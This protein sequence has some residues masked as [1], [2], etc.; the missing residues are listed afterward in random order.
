MVAD[1]SAVGDPL[2]GFDIYDSYK[3]GKECEFPRVEGGW[4]TFGGTSLSTPLIAGLYGLAGGGHGLTYPGL[5]LYGREADASSRFDVTSGGNGICGG[6]VPA[7]CGEP[8]REI[9][10]LV[11][12]EGTTACDAAPGFDGPS[13]VGTPEGFGLFKPEAPTAV[14]SAPASVFAA[15]PAEFDGRSSVD[16]YPGVQLTRYVWSWG[17]GNES[18]GPN[19]THVYASPGKYTVGLTVTDELGLTSAQVTTSVTAATATPPTAVTGKASSITENGATLNATV[20]PNG[21]A[22]TACTFEY[23]T[24]ATPYEKTAPCAT[25]PGSGTT[26]V[27]VSAAVSGLSASTTYH[28]RIVAD[29]ASTTK[30][31]GSDEAFKTVATAPTAVTGKASSITEKGATLNATVNPN[32]TS[33]T[34]CTFEYGTSTTP[35]EK[36]APCATLPGSGTTAVA[37]SAAVSGLSASTTYHFRIVAENTSPTKGEGADEA[38]KTVGPPTAVTGKASSITENGA[39]LNA[40]VNPNGIAVTACTFEYGS[41]AF[42]AIAQTYELTAGCATLPRFGH[43][44]VAVSAAVS[45]LAPNDLPLPRRGR[46]RFHDDQGGRRR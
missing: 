17:D 24:S 10:A 15:A 40:T 18:E 45:G 36:T 21:I 26:P 4:A 3:C 35:Y 43:D 39:T 2:T 44:P 37:V 5:T 32:G 13:G 23:G 27:A 14:I 33:V 6:V 7:V 31:E 22:V 8:N 30:G 11:D 25:L 29:N 34:K 41:A 38:F 42:F 1:V 12:C 46:K 16:A 28:F 20:N 9:G 19:P